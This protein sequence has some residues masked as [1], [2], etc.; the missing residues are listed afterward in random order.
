MT[1]K[2]HAITR[3]NLKTQSGKGQDDFPGS[4]WLSALIVIMHLRIGRLEIAIAMQ[5][6]SIE[7][8][9]N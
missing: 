6:C 2:L 9:N 7:C 8:K 5:L 4:L 1:K 3:I